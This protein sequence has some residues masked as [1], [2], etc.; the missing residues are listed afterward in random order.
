MKP[1]EYDLERLTSVDL[2]L[3]LNR[4]YR[5]RNQ[6]DKMHF[7]RVVTTALSQFGVT[8]VQ[9]VDIDELL[10]KEMLMFSAEPVRIRYRTNYDT[11]YCPDYLVYT[12]VYNVVNQSVCTPTKSAKEGIKMELIHN[13]KQ[14]E[15]QVVSNEVEEGTLHILRSNPKTGVLLTHIEALEKAGIA[16]IDKDYAIAVLCELLSPADKEKLTKLHNQAVKTAS[17]IE[18]RYFELTQLYGITTTYDQKLAL[19]QTYG[20]ISKK[21]Q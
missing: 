6:A 8:P 14:Q 9:E 21:V 4:W 17:T 15:L 16:T 3:K 18:A 11:R 7:L 20:I 12:P 2:G 13:H 5:F 1:Q 10:D 19:L